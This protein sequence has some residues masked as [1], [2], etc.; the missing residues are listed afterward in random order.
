MQ[1]SFICARPGSAGRRELRNF[2][3]V[4]THGRSSRSGNFACKADRRRVASPPATAM[5]LPMRCPGNAVWSTDDPE[6]LSRLWRN[7]ISTNEPLSRAALSFPAP[8]TA[9][10]H[11]LLSSA[12]D[13]LRRDNFRLANPMHVHVR[14]TPPQF[15]TI[16]GTVLRQQRRWW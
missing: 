1:S 7:S 2:I 11:R 14:G 3:S 16:T 6:S 12:V 10:Y 15:A 5:R 8:R 13:N 4:K 9:S